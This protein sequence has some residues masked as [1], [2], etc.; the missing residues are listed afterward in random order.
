MATAAGSAR[1]WRR[2]CR[3]AKASSMITLSAIASFSICLKPPK[4][5]TL[6][7]LFSCWK[8]LSKWRIAPVGANWLLLTRMSRLTGSS[9]DVGGEAEIG[10]EWGPD[11]TRGR[12]YLLGRSLGI[13]GL[14]AHICFQSWENVLCLVEN[15]HALGSNQTPNLELNF[16]WK[17]SL[18]VQPTICRQ[19]LGTMG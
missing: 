2:C 18:L 7:T 5:S 12:V 9:G 4:K 14:A 19:N 8:V 16:N 13:A 3:A 6:Q 17:C 1:A 15:E 10:H 11:R